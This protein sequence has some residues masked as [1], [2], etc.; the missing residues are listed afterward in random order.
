MAFYDDFEK[1]RKEVLGGQNT[2]QNNNSSSSSFNGISTFEQ[3]RKQIL[4]TPPA[5]PSQVAAQEIK[6]TATPTQSSLWDNVKSAISNV[7]SSVKGAIPQLNNK[8]AIPTFSAPSKDQIKTPSSP[9]K[10]LNGLDSTQSP[11][12]AQMTPE[13]LN[14]PQAQRVS[15]ITKNIVDGVLKY[16]SNPV[17]PTVNAALRLVP[18]VNSAMSMYK[19]G[20][21]PL[22]ILKG[23]NNFITKKIEKVNPSLAAVYTGGTFLVP[24]KFEYFIAKEIEKA[25]RELETIWKD[26]R[27]SI[28]EKTGQSV[29]QV[30][31]PIAMYFAAPKIAEKF[32]PKTTQKEILNILGME[33]FNVL[34]LSTYKNLRPLVNVL[35]RGASRGASAMM[36]INAAQIMKQGL[37]AKKSPEDILKTIIETS[38]KNALYGGL[39]GT[40][41][42]GWGVAQPK[43]FG[44]S[45][46]GETVLTPEQARNQVEGTD[47]G[48]KDPKLAEIINTASLK[49]QTEGKNVKISTIAGFEGEL[50]KTIGYEKTKAIGEVIGTGTTPGGIKVRVE[51]VDGP[52]PLQKLQSG[53]DETTSPTEPNIPSVVKNEIVNRESQTT[54]NKSETI[55]P[56]TTE[57]VRGS[58]HPTPSLEIS[59]DKAASYGQGIYMYEGN[60]SGKTA[61]VDH[62]PITGKVI[63]ISPTRDLKLYTPTEDER[64]NITDLEGKKQMDYIKTLLG[65]KYDGLRIVKPSYYGT[66]GEPEIVVYDKSLVQINQATQTEVKQP[67]VKM[68]KMSEVES[69]LSEYIQKNANTATPKIKAFEQI[70]KDGGSLEPIPVYF[71]NGKYILN[72]DGFHRLQALKNQGRTDIQVRIESKTNLDASSKQRLENKIKPKENLPTKQNDNFYIYQWKSETEK[73]FKQIQAKA[74]SIISGIDTFIHKDGPLWV[75]SEGMTGRKITDGQTRAQAIEKVKNA[76]RKLIKE[77][78]AKKM[79]GEP[80]S[81]RYKSGKEIP[82]YAEAQ[83]LIAKEGGYA[84]A[85]S[86]VAMNRM[87]ADEIAQSMGLNAK[88][89]YTEATKKGINLRHYLARIDAETDPNKR[90]KISEELMDQLSQGGEKKATTPPLSPTEGVSPS[91]VQNIAGGGDR[92]GVSPIQKEEKLVSILQDKILKNDTAFIK[93]LEER[94]AKNPDPKIK[95]ILEDSIKTANERV[96]KIKSDTAKQRVLTTEAKKYNTADEFIKAIG[97][98]D[99]DFEDIV[100][101]HGTQ[102]GAELTK[103]IENGTVRVSENGLIGK[104]FYVTSSQELGEYFGKQV[105]TTGGANRTTVST[106][107]DVLAIDMTGL[108]I[109]RQDFGKQDYYD[110]LEKN[111]L[112]PQSY[113]DQLIKEGYDGL[114][115][116]GRGETVI[117]DPKKVQLM[118]LQKVFDD[119]HKPIEKKQ[120]PTTQP[121]KNSKA[122]G[123]ANREPFAEL[124]NI[125]SNIA[126]NEIKII[127]FP[128]MLRLADTLMGNRPIA[129]SSKRGQWLGIFRSGGTGQILLKTDIFKSPAQAA[130][131]LSHEIGHLIDYLPDQDLGRGNLLGRIGTMRNFLR[132]TFSNPENEAKIDSLFAE[133][134]P[135]QAERRKLKDEKGN[136]KPENKE[137]DKALL[138]EIRPLNAQIREL[139]KNSIKNR[140][141]RIELM[142]LSAKWRPIEGGKGTWEDIKDDG[143]RSGSDELYA[144]AISVLFNDPARLQQ[145]APTFWKGFFDHLDQKPEVKDNLFKLYELLSGDPEKIFRERDEAMSK[146]YAKAEDAF[147]ALHVEKQKRVT[148]LVEDIRILFD[149]K[150]QAVINKAQ[151]A[152]KMGINIAPENNPLYTLPALNYI[153]G[154]IKNYI[155]ESFQPIFEKAQSVPDGWNLL[156]KVLQLERTIYERGEMANPGG[157]DPKTA[158]D[159]LTALETH[160]DANDWAKIQ[161]AKQGFRE[162]VQKSISEAEMNG[163][164][165][166]EMIEKMKANP[167]YATYQ[168]I[169]YLDTYVSAGV[170]QAVGTLKDVANPATSTVMKTISLVKAIERNNA[171]KNVV[172][173]LLNAFPGEIKQS[174]MRFNGRSMEIKETREKDKGIVAVIKDGKLVGYDVDKKIADTLGFVSNETIKSAAKLMRMISLAPIYRPLFTSFNLGFQSFNFVR[175]FERYWKN[176]PDYTLSEALTSFPRAIYRYGQA[177]KH[178][179]N[180]ALGIDDKLVKEM[181]NAKILGMNFADVF[182]DPIDPEDAEIERVLQGVGILNK[183]KKQNKILFP[184]V[185]TLEGVEILGNLIESLPKIA[186]YI[187]LKGKMQGEEL[188]HFIRTKIGSPDFKTG[189]TATPITN[190][191]FLFS[192]A[193]KEGI[194]SDIQIA[195]GKAGKQSQSGFWWKTIVATILPKIIMAAMGAGLLG[196]ALKDQVDGVSEYDKSQYTI[197]PMGLDENGKTKY[198]RIPQDETSRVIGAIFWKSLN[199]L[200]KKE[201][202]L[203]DFLQVIDVGA[204][205]LPN[206]APSFTSLGVIL[207]YIAGQNPYDSFRGRN[208]IPDQAF[209]AGP[210]YSLPI[211]LSWLAQTN[212]LGL[213]MPSYQPQNPSLLEK[214]LNLPGVGNTVG[215]WMKVSDYGKTEQNQAITGKIKQEKAAAAIEDKKVLDNAVK[216][217]QKGPQNITQKMKAEKQLI[218]DVL[219]KPPYDQ[220]ERTKRTNL[221]KKFRISVLRGKVDVDVNSLITAVSTDERV[222]LL[223]DIS[224]G[225]SAT[226]MQS[227]LKEMNKQGVLSI[228]AIQTYKRQKKK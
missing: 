130:K 99:V 208:V 84:N 213:I 126:N 27:K 60:A 104:G 17:D 59:P 32:I 173:L 34:K 108:N 176:T 88:Y 220:S 15:G 8:P 66:A 214:M 192:N 72:K 146:A 166:P 143:Y 141:V 73:G 93:Q 156:G 204:G 82:S 216:A 25:P 48:S 29:G 52:T 135:L 65:D 202:G 194:K 163:Y 222:A 118:D 125:T 147:Y 26:N 14:S 159:Q 35:A 225:K 185:K 9:V 5:T 148:N 184:I 124:E 178:A 170:K 6:K 18:G 123:Y 56:M 45:K 61:A 23:I 2:T 79:E 90:L 53:T 87:A 188:A 50:T 162:A 103:A 186:G 138:R 39:F 28:L 174:E 64:T 36:L 221:L 211:L 206:L 139:Q 42:E 94:I 33:S 113:N 46:A 117:F 76:G 133:V 116:L 97:N 140:V 187:E 54:T 95:K 71:E 62:A 153:N 227:F 171:K 1:R 155:E 134:K 226:E 102:K 196:V 57:L 115:L 215:R 212:G 137:K 101:F 145:E 43:L 218:L 105:S 193:I 203:S 19:K 219:G 96:N 119:A 205:Q 168:V 41:A 150:N 224:K 201:A 120:P 106:K 10:P 144:D 91:R 181:E 169:D 209:T 86:L 100:Q 207:Q 197:I 49:A 132:G 40:V 77:T 44:Y 4:E 30:A 81:P 55:I 151:Q 37:D 11:N 24:G 85:H 189:G 13:A 38:P 83:K 7:I 68:V 195:S 109:K 200:S 122:S 164:Y 142:N 92:G 172:D 89:L 210:K 31:V 70:L 223:N 217:Y 21:E 160:T 190:S 58:D 157:Y 182:K 112:T 152:M 20:T 183:E 121:I 16:A 131:T 12:S 114:N 175:D 22:D 179:K 136:V 63:S 161:E 74:I 80:L 198:M 51:V 78:I 3:R 110:F 67:E 154:K 47:I 129:T 75:I 177:F 228:Q 128:E 69:G 165:S 199:M 180:R 127:E 158:Q 111:K 191:M 98:N 167:A 149:S 107:P